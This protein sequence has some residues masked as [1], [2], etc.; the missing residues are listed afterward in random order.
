MVVIAIVLGLM[1]IGD[2]VEIERLKERITKLE[3]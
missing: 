3:R 2:R 1:I